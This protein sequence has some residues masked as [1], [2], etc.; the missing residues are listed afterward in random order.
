MEWDNFDYLEG[1]IKNVASEV[2]FLADELSRKKLASDD[3]GWMTDEGNAAAALHAYNYEIYQNQAQDCKKEIDKINAQLSKDPYNKTLLDRRDALVQSYQEVI[4]STEDEKYAV[5][6]LYKQGYDALSNKIHTL[7]GDY[8]DLL[9]AEKNAYDYQNT[10]ADKTK[11]IAQ[12]RKQLTA[13]AGDLSEETR[14]KVQTL[15]VSLEN[16]EKELAETQYEKYISDTKDMLSEMQEDFDQ[17]VQE[18]VDALA[19][20]FGQLLSDL[21][22]KTA[23]AAETITSAM[24]GIGY[25]PTDE[26]RKLLYGEETEGNQLPSI[27]ASAVNMLAEMQKF[28]TNMQAYAAAVANAIDPSSAAENGGAGSGNSGGSGGGA[29]SNGSTNQKPNAVVVTEEKPKDCNAGSWKEACKKANAKT[30]GRFLYQ[31]PSVENDLKARKAF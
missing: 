16:A 25:M 5:I 8:N 6:D 17:S 18:I 24:T 27:A 11:E 15:K 28:N 3:L 2:S 12:I 1:R 13:Y 21:D 4:K 7:I 22:T 14:S 20:N 19:E 10:I 30:A 23:A 29:S 31:S 26:F 9:D